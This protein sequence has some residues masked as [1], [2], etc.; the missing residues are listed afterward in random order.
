MIILT[1]VSGTMMIVA[2]DAHG[3]SPRLR[4][5]RYKALS[6]FLAGRLSAGLRVEA[7]MLRG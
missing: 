2:M 5:R 6:G 3:E 7:G 4:S 1:A